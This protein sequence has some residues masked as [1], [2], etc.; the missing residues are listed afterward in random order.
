MKWTRE[1]VLLALRLYLETPFGQQ[2]STHPPIVDLAKK[3][4]R[5]P[6]AVAMRLSNFTS[7]DPQ[8]AERGVRGLTGASQLVKSVWSEYQ[9]SPEDIIL[10]AESLATEPNRPD[11]SDKKLEGQAPSSSEKWGKTK[12]RLGQRFFR[13]GVLASYGHR[14]CISGNPIPQVLRAGHIIPWAQSEEHRLNLR[15]G[16]CMEATYDAAFD[17]GLIS[18]SSG[19]KIQVS[20]ALTG[21][22]G[23]NEEVAE[24][25]LSL[26]G[27]EI[28]LPEKNLPEKQFLA[29]HFEHVFHS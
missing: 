26:A 2:H 9:A 21:V 28:R 10:E 14:C 24:R 1:E 27:F 23:D 20:P 5:T 16:L 22:Y 12:V 15:N 4:N 18:V 25:F 19:Y 17:A 3:I 29:W 6:G 8:E 13:R 11:E 7:L